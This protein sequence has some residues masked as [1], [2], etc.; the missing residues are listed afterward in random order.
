MAM[1]IAFL[2]GTYLLVLSLCAAMCG[3]NNAPLFIFVISEAA[4]P[5]ESMSAR[6]SRQNCWPIYDE[7]P[8]SVCC[9]SLG[10]IV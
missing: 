10:C 7:C 6:L 4:L 8:G 5:F 1:K 9:C 2:L 3:V